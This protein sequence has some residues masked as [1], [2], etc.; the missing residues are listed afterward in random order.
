MAVPSQMFSPNFFLIHAQA[1]AE[2]VNFFFFGGGGGI[3]LLEFVSKRLVSK[4]IGIKMTGLVS[5]SLSIK[6]SLG[7]VAAPDVYL[8]E[9]YK[10]QANW[11]NDKTMVLNSICELSWL[12][13]VSP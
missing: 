6:L 11:L 13:S 9:I 12:F 3:S 5:Q 4:Q 10:K 2:V 7:I 1:I 8:K